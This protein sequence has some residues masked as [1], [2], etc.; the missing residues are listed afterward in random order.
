[1]DL[2]KWTCTAYSWLHGDNCRLVVTSHCSGG[3][4]GVLPKKAAKI[5]NNWI[6]INQQ[7]QQQQQQALIPFKEK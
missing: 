1:M 5:R 6:T 7:Q 4:S 2:L 3:P